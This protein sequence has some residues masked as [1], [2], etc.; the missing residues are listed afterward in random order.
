VTAVPPKPTARLRGS[1]R[2]RAQVEPLPGAPT[3]VLIVLVIAVA[4][5]AAHALITGTSARLFD[6]W[7]HD[8]VLLAA[9]AVCGIGARRH[10]H[11]RHGWTYIAGAV[12][13]I[14]LSDVLWSLLY[15]NATTIPYP[16]YTDIFSLA[17]YPLFMTGL[18]LIVRHRVSHF[19]LQ[20]WLDGLVIL[21][22][23]AI[24]TVALVLQPALRQARTDPLAQIVTVSYPLGD[25]LLL[26][27]LLGAVPLMSWRMDASWY[28]LGLGLLCLTVGDAVYAM[29]AVDAVYH[30]G[31]YDFLWSAGCLAIAIAAW[32]PATESLP[33]LEPVGWP[34]IILPLGAQIFAVA[35]QVYGYFAPL[36]RT[37]RLL[38]IAVLGIG[39]AQVIAGRPQT[40]PNSRERTGPPREQNK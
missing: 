28:W 24:P 9:A 8:A 21:L 30:A 38:T 27:A 37:E 35:T 20:R 18:V 4:V 14:A 3:L 15:G 5:E 34:A 36:P 10:T 7:L 33:G 13:C 2:G 23:V 12:L 17:S 6:D 32:R 19:E 1:V 16:N 11:E 39:I 31:R 22:I 29:A 26:G 40:R 25:L